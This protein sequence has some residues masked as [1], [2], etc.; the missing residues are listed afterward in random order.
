MRATSPLRRYLDLLAISSSAPWAAGAEPLDEVRMLECAVQA[1]S[2]ARAVR[3]TERLANRHWTL[4]WL[5]QRPGWSGEAELVDAR[6]RR[7]LAVIPDLALETPV[8]LAAGGRPGGR[9]EVTVR[10]VDLPRLDLHLEMRET[11]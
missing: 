3:G 2:A 11:D 8:S 9:Y 5:Q 6:G 1:E 10:H 7:G 4:V